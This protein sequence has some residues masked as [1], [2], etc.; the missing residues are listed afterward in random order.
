M[1]AATILNTAFLRLCRD[2][3]SGFDV[4]L[5]EDAA[6]A[7]DTGEAEMWLMKIASGNCYL[8][9]TNDGLGLRPCLI[10]S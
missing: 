8:S 5:L 3:I 6:F 2:E 10:A 7:W 9:L 1:D 4:T